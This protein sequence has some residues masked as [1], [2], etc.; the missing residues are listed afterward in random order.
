MTNRR[1]LRWHYIKQEEQNTLKLN[2]NWKSAY[3][4]SEL[5]WIDFNRKDEVK[6]RK[7]RTM[8]YSEHFYPSIGGSENYALD[9]AK[10]LYKQGHSVMVVTSEKSNEEES[11]P[12]Q[13]IRIYKKFPGKAFNLNFSVSIPLKKKLTN[14]SPLKPADKK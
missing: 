8:I 5:S 3:K 7:L 6:G 2:E 10:E 9:L 13:V 11:F 4:M 12:F 1:L 14:F